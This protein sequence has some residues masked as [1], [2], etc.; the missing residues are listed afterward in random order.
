MRE[1]CKFTM[2]VSFEG[3]GLSLLMSVIVGSMNRE[4]IGQERGVLD[5]YALEDGL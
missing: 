4:K 2:P 5:A 3:R 1:E